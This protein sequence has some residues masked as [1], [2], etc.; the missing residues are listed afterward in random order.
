MFRAVPAIATRPLLGHTLIFRTSFVRVRSNGARTT[1]SLVAFQLLFAD[2]STYHA[3]W[4]P[5]PDRTYALW[6]GWCMKQKKFC[7]VHPIVWR[8]MEKDHSC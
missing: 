3:T 1:R 4:C 7:E 2:G 5:L 6:C 8:E